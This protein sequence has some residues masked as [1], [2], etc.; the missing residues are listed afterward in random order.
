MLLVYFLPRFSLEFFHPIDFVAR[1]KIYKCCNLTRVLARGK[2]G[3]KARAYKIPSFPPSHLSNLTRSRVNKMHS[4]AKPSLHLHGRA[5][6]SARLRGRED[7]ALMNLSRVLHH[8]Y[9]MTCLGAKEEREGGKGQDDLGVAGPRSRRR[10][11]NRKFQ[12]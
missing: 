2:V 3:P 9:P 1:K 6:R 11:S 4:F 7:I 10:D 12:N 8:Q 5:V